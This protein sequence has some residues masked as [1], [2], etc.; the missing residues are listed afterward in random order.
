MKR[1][2]PSSPQDAAEQERGAHLQ[3]AQRHRKIVAGSFKGR[4]ALEPEFATPGVVGKLALSFTTTGPLTKH[5]RITCQLPDHG[6]TLPTASPPNV[7]LQLPSPNE[8]AATAALPQVKMTWGPS[9][10]TMEF[11]LLNESVIPADTPL[12]LVV[13]GVGTPEKATPQGEAI[14]TTFEKL[15][16]RSTVPTST[17]GGQIVDGPAAFTIPKIVP[18]S[19]DSTRRK[20]ARGAAPGWMGYG[21]TAQGAA[22]HT[23]VS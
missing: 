2:S 19:I 16:V 4:K 21:R 22:P 20:I 11:T 13:S 5:A 18:G 3:L 17:R 14:V 23:G 1:L 15:V 12:V 9:T 10:R 7:V 6:W 8:H